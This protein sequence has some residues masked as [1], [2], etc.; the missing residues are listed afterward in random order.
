[1]PGNDTVEEMINLFR[2]CYR[3]RYSIRLLMFFFVSVEVIYQSYNII[4]ESDEILPMN[5]YSDQVMKSQTFDI[6]DEDKCN[7]G[8]GSR[9]ITLVLVFVVFSFM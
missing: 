3:K 8:S 4:Y 9:S 1:M 6:C 7:I 2:D 5:F